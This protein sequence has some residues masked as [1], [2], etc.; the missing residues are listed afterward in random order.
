MAVHLKMMSR[1]RNLSGAIRLAED[2]H[3]LTEGVPKFTIHAPTTTDETLKLLNDIAGKIKLPKEIIAADLGSGLGSFACS[4]SI[5]FDQLIARNK[6]SKFSVTG[7]DLSTELIEDAA[8]IAQE[9][10]IRNVSFLNRDFTKFSREDLKP[11]NLV[12]IY[13]NFKNPDLEQALENIFPLLAADAK[14]ITRLCG[15][16]K[17]LRSDLFW[18]AFHPLKD[19]Y[20]YEYGLFI[21]TAK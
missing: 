5:Y 17:V 14:L 4:A 9:Q 20:G 13:Q 11:Y 12:Y 18:L 2:K 1:M 6:I 7:F 21:R 15:N 16:V 8:R 10:K 19:K 3:L